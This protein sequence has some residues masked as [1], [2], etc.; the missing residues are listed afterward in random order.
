MEEIIQKIEDLSKSK[1]LVNAEQVIMSTVHDV[2]PILK[3]PISDNL[4]DKLFT[5]LLA[6]FTINKGGFSLQCGTYIATKLVRLLE[7]SQSPKFWDVIS[8]SIECNTPAAFVATGYVCSK[9]GMHNKSQIP[10]FLEHLIKI[11]PPNHAT[12]HSIRLALKSG[13]KAVSQFAPTIFELLKKNISTAKP[14]LIML[15]LKLLRTLLKI[16]PITISQ[17]LE[18]VKLAMKHKDQP[19][20]KNELALVIARCAYFPYA[21]IDLKKRFQTSEFSVGALRMENRTLKFEPAFQIISMFQPILSHSFTH[22]LNLLGPELISMNH[23]KLFNFIRPRCPDVVKHLIPM[24]PAD[25]RFSYFRE[26]SAEKMSAEQL[27]TLTILCPDDGS[28]DEAA[29]VAL[30]LATSDDKT[31]R[32]VAI[33]YFAEL[34]NTHPQIVLPYLHSALVLL[35]Q[36]PEKNPRILRDLKGNASVALTILRNLPDLQMAIMQNKIILEKLL[37]DVFTKP[38]ATA[39]KFIFSFALL[40]F[41]PE[42]FAD[43]TKAVDFAIDYFTKK[44]EIKPPKMTR[45]LLKSVFNYRAKFHNDEQNKRLLDIAISFPSPLPFSVISDL[46]KIIQSSPVAFSASKLVLDFALSVAPSYVLIK[47]FI[48][49]PLPIAQDLICKRSLVASQ[50]KKHDK[51]LHRFVGNFPALLKACAPEDQKKL[52]TQLLRT[53]TVTSTLI[54]TSISNLITILPPKYPSIVLKNIES[55]NTLLIECLA[56]SLAIYATATPQALSEIYGYVLSH[57]NVSSCILLSAIFMHIN[58]PN[59][60]V[61]QSLIA[62]DSLVL[63]QGCTPMALHALNSLLMTHQMQ[64]SSLEIAA[65]QF[66]MLFQALNT[67]SSLQPVT[68]HIMG[69]CYGCLIE[70]FSSDIS[71]RFSLMVELILRTIESTPMDYAREVYFECSQSIYTFANSMSYLAPLIF[72]QSRS[73]P[74][75]LQLTSCAA[76]SDF[77]KFQSANF[78]LTDLIPKLLTLLQRTGDERASHFIIALASLMTEDDVS[79]WIS[80]IKRVLISCSL[81]DGSSFTIEPTPEVK[82]SCLK[83]ATYIVPHIANQKKL[84]TE[85]LDDLISSVCRATE[86]DRVTLQE[87]AFPTL[88]KVIDLFKDRITEEGQRLL[89]LYDSQFS[90]AVKVGFRVNLAVSGGFLSNYLTFNTDNMQNDPENCSA[91]LVVYLAGLRECPQRSN[92]YFSLATHLCTVARKYPPLCELIQPFLKTLTPIFYELVTQ[93]MHLWNPTS[94]WRALSRFRTLAQSFFIELLPA[95]VWLQSITETVMDIDVLTSFI[96]VEMMKGKEPWIAQA[97]FESLPVVIDAFGSKI[98]PQLLELSISIA[99]GYIKNNSSFLSTFEALLI[100]SAAHITGDSEYD[101]IRTNILSL[102]LGLK[103]FSPQIFAHLLKSDFRKTL[104]FYTP[105]IFNVILTNWNNKAINAL[106]VVLFTHS[107]AVIGG[108]IIK[109]IENKIVPSEFKIEVITRGLLLSK[110]GIPLDFISRFCI[111][112]F[113]KG[114][115][116][117]IGRIIVEREDVGIALLSE[118]AAKAA[119]LLSS[120]EKGN[121]R[122]YLRFIQLSLNVLEKNTSISTK[123]ARSAVILALTV[124]SKFG[125]DVTRLGHQI[126]CQCVWILIDARKILKEKYEDAFNECDENER[127]K[128]I[129]NITHHIRAE[130]QRKKVDQLVEFSTNDRGKKQMEW[131]TLEIEGIDD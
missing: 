61:N 130:E 42:G 30:L 43:A 14:G 93:E 9:V 98:S 39:Y 37:N 21:S 6:L 123:F 15:Y 44:N 105:A 87:A 57:K 29:G 104:K 11:D 64:I 89:D 70:A 107:P 88:Q 80:T 83:V 46:C 66:P 106:I 13:E 122:A 3:Q 27:K 91:I 124:A 120:V 111:G 33:D 79:F 16:P 95:F 100:D 121:C 58:L 126:L 10:R 7:L 35:A 118:G 69:E 67:S 92:S 26:V 2:D 63:V 96:L 12:L 112:T 60:Y 56:E 52:V 45:S 18:C 101:K 116:H 17:I 49:R 109:T 74:A 62:I 119:F 99:S 65:H 82:E 68:L 110:G 20:I 41:L 40:S 53:V 47:K 84:N 59:N 38:R 97:A 117:M 85:N 86:T 31:A 22:F 25:L 48:K 108:S 103:T 72:P 54:L 24:L 114:A 131:Q 75:S 4:A 51:F 36:P 127:S 102:A 28:I 94:D 78:N 125:G 115:M 71:P 34:A 5:A 113:K 81:L 19:F 76:F 32:R 90:M 73:A 129:N 128:A 55:K 77:L 1:N 50:Q 8:M 23:T